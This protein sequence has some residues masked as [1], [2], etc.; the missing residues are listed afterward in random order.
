MPD[1]NQA[2]FGVVPW[3]DMVH[4]HE[5]ASSSDAAKAAYWRTLK[6]LAILGHDHPREQLFFRNELLAR[7][8]SAEEKS[9][10]C[11]YWVG[12][13]YQWLSDFG[14]S[15]SRPLLA[16]LAVFSGF[17]SLYRYTGS[18]DLPCA[19]SEWWVALGLSLQ[20][21]LPAL[22]GRDVLPQFYACLYGTQDGSPVIPPWIWSLGVG[23]TLASTVLI[24]LFLLAVRN[25]FRV[26]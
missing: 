8:G 23:Q 5:K 2:A 4:I 22:A 24:F 25:H 11:A 6:R 15:L 14:R 18:G 1:F 20:R 19:T 17:T 7:R 10:H 9:W 13:L 21:S 26:R 12:L 16:W 3:L